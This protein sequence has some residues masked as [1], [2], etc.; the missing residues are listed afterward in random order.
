MAFHLYLWC[1]QYYYS[2]FVR[3]LPCIFTY[4]AISTTPIL[5]WEHCW[6]LCERGLLSLPMLPSALLFFCDNITEFCENIAFHPYP[7]CHNG[8]STHDG[9]SDLVSSSWKEFIHGWWSSHPVLNKIMKP[10]W[11]QYVNVRH[12]HEVPFLPNL[13]DRA[14]SL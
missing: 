14:T 11:G 4:A 9:V 6:I 8:G 13:E 12:V 10:L 2:F 1:H 5:L 3:T 7:C